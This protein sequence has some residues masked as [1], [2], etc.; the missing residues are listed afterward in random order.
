MRMRSC[1]SA[2]AVAVVFSLAVADVAEH[3]VAIGDPIAVTAPEGVDFGTKKPKVRALLIPGDPAAKGDPKLKLKVVEFTGTTATLLVKQA[4]GQ[5]SF[6]V[7]LTPKGGDAVSVAVATTQ[8]PDVQEWADEVEIGGELELAGE[9]FGS[10]KGKVTIGG[11]PAKVLDW[12]NTSVTVR[13][14]K[15][16]ALG[17]SDLVVTTKIGTTTVAE[18]VDVLEPESEE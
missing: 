7:Q 11:K 1:L 3:D 14:H 18:A 10:K 13:V 6:D 8:V 17:V 9:Y 15:K 5:G 16:A 4:K 12:T 2:V